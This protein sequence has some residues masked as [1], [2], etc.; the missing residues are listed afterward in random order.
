MD[1]APGSPARAHF[2]GRA[3]ATETGT[4]RGGAAARAGASE[5]GPQREHG[6]RG[7]E[8]YVNEFFHYLKIFSFVPTLFPVCS[9]FVP[10]HDQPVTR[11]NPR[12]LFFVPTVPTV[13]RGMV[14]KEVEK[15]PPRP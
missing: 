11:M 6:K 14:P 5:S 3:Q 13:L 10:T 4:R 1:A 7:T 2:R 12:L 8:V 9:H 15:P